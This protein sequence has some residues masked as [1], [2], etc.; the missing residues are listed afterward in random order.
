MFAVKFYFFIFLLYFQ[1]AASQ[2]PLDSFN[3]TQYIDICIPFA[4]GLQVEAMSQYQL[5][6]GCQS[7]VL[8]Y[9]EMLDLK[10]CELEYHLKKNTNTNYKG[11]MSFLSSYIDDDRYE[12]IIDWI[13]RGKLDKYEY[14]NIFLGQTVYNMSKVFP[15]ME[16]E[17]EY[18]VV[19]LDCFSQFIFPIFT[20]LVLGLIL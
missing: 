2:S 1:K 6:K 17:T 3:L 4:L 18:E 10:C 7:L 5:Q 16:N 9:P 14:Y 8:P 12:D 15:L 19:K 11:C 20:I 13:E